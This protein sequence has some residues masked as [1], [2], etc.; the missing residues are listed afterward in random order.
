MDIFGSR[1]ASTD[2]A[3]FSQAK[4]LILKDIRSRWGKFSEAELERL[5]DNDDLV[6]QIA[7]KYGIDRTQAQAEVDAVM[8]GRRL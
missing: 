6:G 3:K 4:R 5:G 7:D 2:F 8:L 1:Q